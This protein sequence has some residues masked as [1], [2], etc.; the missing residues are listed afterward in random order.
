METAVK[1][2]A[3]PQAPRPTDRLMEALATLAA[4]LDRTINEVRNVDGEYQNRLMEAVHKTEESLQAQSAKHIE[5]AR[6]E[7][8]TELTQRF[9]ADLQ[10]SLDTL[11]ADFQGER[12]RLSTDSSAERERLSQELRHASDSMSELQV[13]RSKLIAELQH[14]KESAA[15]DVEKMRSEAQAAVDAAA[16][17]ASQQSHVPEAEIQR[18]EAELAEVVRVIEDP[19]TDLSVVIRKNVEKVELI[20]YLRGLR[21]TAKS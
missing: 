18:V 21:F 4:L 15:A 11:R 13:E 3:T 5:T 10:S 2:K 12:E 6:E 7:V 16:K 9:Q 14:V 19:A 8:R 17:A 20:A 1:Q